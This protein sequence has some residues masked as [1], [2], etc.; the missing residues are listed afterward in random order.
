MLNIVPVPGIGAI[1]AGYRN[2]H[3]PLLRHGI[4]QALLVAFG[5]WPLI[6]PGLIGLAWAIRTAMII[7][8]A[9]QPGRRTRPVEGMDA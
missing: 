6:L 9:Q 7:D 4:A 3:S 8:G 2:P 1:I 5:S